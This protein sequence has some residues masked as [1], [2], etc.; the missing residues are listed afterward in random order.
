MTKQSISEIHQI[1]KWQGCNSCAFIH[2]YCNANGGN[3]CKRKCVKEATLGSRLSDYTVNL[4]KWRH[5][6][7]RGLLKT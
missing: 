3:W 4:N 1:P 7:T 6:R 5:A 2:N